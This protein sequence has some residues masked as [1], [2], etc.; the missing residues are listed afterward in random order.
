MPKPIQSAIQASLAHNSEIT[1]N[2]KPLR[3]I[4]G[5]HKTVS[6]WYHGPGLALFSRC[7]LNSM[8]FQYVTKALRSYHRSKTQVTIVSHTQCV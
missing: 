1:I 5:G 8:R 7:L 2:H 6:L 4:S 3:L